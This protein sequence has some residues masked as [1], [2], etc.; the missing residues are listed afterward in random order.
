MA[1]LAEEQR[2]KRR[3]QAGVGGALALVVLALGTTWLL[4]GFDAKEQPVT[5]PTCQWTQRDAGD[6]ITE[7]GLPPTTVP[8]SGLRDLVLTTNQGEIHTLVD[9]SSGSCGA[10]SVQFLASLG[11]Y[12]DTR[13]DRLDTDVRVLTC[14][15][16][17]SPN[18]Q[19]QVEGTPRMPVGTASPVPDPTRSP[20]ADPS[21]YYAKGAVLL[22]N[23]EVN[24][25]GSKI[26]IVYDDNTPLQAQY[27]QIGTVSSGLDLVQQIAAGGATDA[28][29]AASPVGNPV[30]DLTITSVRMDSIPA[31]APATT[32]S[33]TPTV[34]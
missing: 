27:T 13:C 30:L 29:G 14:G 9:L 33:A 31:D 16:D 21:S 12:N 1:K 23:V 2:R 17:K 3:V 8:T 11:F 18:Y 24:A 32:E 22:D 10:A 15:G 5:L 6:G 19:G 28:N 34:S 25:T 20:D 4:G 26:M 7:T